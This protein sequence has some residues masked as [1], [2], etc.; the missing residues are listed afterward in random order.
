MFLFIGEWI[1]KNEA[2][3]ISMIPLVGCSVMPYRLWK[4]RENKE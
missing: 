4:G 2:L 1:G 3:F